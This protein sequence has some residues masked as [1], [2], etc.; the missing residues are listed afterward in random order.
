MFDGMEDY[1]VTFI[2]HLLHADAGKEIL[3]IGYQDDV[4]K[5]CSGLHYQ[6]Q[7]SIKDVL[8]EEV[9]GLILCGGWYSDIRLELVELIQRI[10]KDRKLLAAIGGAGTVMLAKAGVLDYMTYTTSISKWDAE[11]ALFYGMEDPF[12]RENYV[13]K[14]LVRD[15]HVMTAQG[16]AFVDFALEICAWFKLFHSQH[17]K[18][19][20]SKLIK[21]N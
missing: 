11:E 4:I 21:G 8:K 1:E 10:H 9:E 12:P 17:E 19:E 14:R 5:G 13:A 7:F 15:R 6:P 20:F 16:I 3:T 18:H 2:S